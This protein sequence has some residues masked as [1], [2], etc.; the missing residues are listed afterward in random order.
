MDQVSS[1]CVC[2]QYNSLSFIEV[3]FLMLKLFFLLECTYDSKWRNGE[4]GVGGLSTQ[5]EMCNAF[6]WYYPKQDIDQ[7]M[8]AYPVDKHFAD[9]GITNFTG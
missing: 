9:F 4:I 2:C 1:E 6:I 7:C 3:L 8:S 5:E